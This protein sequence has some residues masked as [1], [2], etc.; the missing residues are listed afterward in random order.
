MRFIKFTSLCLPVLILLFANI[1]YADRDNAC[2]DCNS[3]P[4]P[5]PPRVR[6]TISGFKECRYDPVT[7][8]YN[9]TSSSYNGEHI[10]DRSNNAMWGVLDVNGM[11]IGPGFLG[12][13]NVPPLFVGIQ[14]YDPVEGYNVIFYYSGY[15]S[16]HLGIV[17]CPFESNLLNPEYEGYGNWG[18]T[19]CDGNS[20]GCPNGKATVEFIWDLDGFEGDP[21]YLATSLSIDVSD[22]NS[23]LK[24]GC[25]D[26]CEAGEE[27]T[28]IT[29]RCD[30]GCV[31]CFGTINV[32]PNNLSVF[33]DVD[34]KQ[35]ENEDSVTFSVHSILGK[36]AITGTVTC[37]G[38]FCDSNNF[39]ITSTE[40]ISIEPDMASFARAGSCSGLSNC[41]APGD[42]EFPSIGSVESPKFSIGENPRDMMPKAIPDTPVKT[43]GMG[44]PIISVRIPGESHTCNLGSPSGFMPGWSALVDGNN[45]IIAVG[46]DGRQYI[47]PGANNYQLRYIRD[48]ADVNLVI[49]D[50]NDTNPNQIEFVKDATDSNLKY[51]YSYDASGLLT[52]LTAWDYTDSREFALNYDASDRLI[53]VDGTCGSCGGGCSGGGGVHE[54]VFDANNV[55]TAVK[56]AADNI[57]HEFE[58]NDYNRI[59]NKYRGPAT[60]S[61]LINSFGYSYYGDSINY[62]DI[63]DFISEDTYRVRREYRN[64]YGFTSKTISYEYLNEDPSDPDGDYFVEHIL[65]TYDSNGMMVEKVVIPPIGDSNDYPDSSTGIR[66][67]YTY[68]DS[69]GDLLTEKWY[70]RDDNCITAS[71]YSY[72]YIMTDDGNSV[73]ATRVAAYTDA[74]GEVTNYYY[75]GNDTDPNL[76]VMPQVSDGISG[77][78][79]IKRRYTYDNQKRVTFEELLSGD[80]NSIVSK[81][82]YIYDDYGNIISR[83]EYLNPAVDDSNQATSYEYNGFNE[84]VLMILPSG[85]MEGFS[86]NASGKVDYE[87]TYDPCDTDYVYSKTQYVYDANGRTVKVAR[88]L[89]DGRFELTAE[90]NDTTWTWTEYEYDLWGNRTKVIED[91]NGLGLE[92]SYEYN[93]LGEITKVTLPNGKWIKTTRDGRGLATEQVVG[94]YDTS[95]SEDVEVSV[96]ESRYD[97]NGNLQWQSSPNDPDSASDDVWTRYYYDDYDRLIK[98]TRGL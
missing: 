1:S 31:Y 40:V 96:V 5:L 89:Y 17:G 26:D 13:H 77:T 50:Y 7:G 10:L 85:V 64:Y 92:T 49:Y 36:E 74:M 23:V 70:D 76:Q 47:Y 67:E 34:P 66:K 9:V 8:D 33:A 94:Y 51:E 60:D 84:K 57:L 58:Y 41:G 91:A 87:V 25:I 72:D 56:D 69:T 32:E 21:N 93:F 68:D 39:L 98:V 22:Y 90:P 95:E 2:Y 62:V 71:S 44:R 88:A 46:P 11:I 45:D 73:F 53:S 80:S 3:I 27:P 20:L 83:H 61:N 16:G 35:C 82:G 81:T 65:Y 79:K 28:A 30:D 86:Y 75:D 12:R 18:C 54:Y 37:T 55:V 14:E 15:E 43:D 38:V 63:K 4:Y 97:D 59:L 24:Y 19:Y 6:V 29:M 52:N 78:Q 42:P 48:A